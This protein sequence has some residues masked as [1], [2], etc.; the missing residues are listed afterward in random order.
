MALAAL[1]GADGAATSPAIIAAREPAR[2]RQPRR[3]RAG[4]IGKVSRRRLGL[5]GGAADRPWAFQGE[6][7]DPAGSGCP[8]GPPPVVVPPTADTFLQKPLCHAIRPFM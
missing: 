3:K 8:A 7:G 1:A 5:E 2:A 6:V 4:G